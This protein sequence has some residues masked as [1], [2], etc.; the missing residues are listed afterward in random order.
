M[1]NLNKPPISLLTPEAASE[2]LGVDR[3][4]VYL[5]VADDKLPHIQLPDRGEI[6]LPMHAMLTSICAQGLE[7]GP[8]LGRLD[9]TA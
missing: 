1:S 3:E 4:K 2:L 6:R 7:I 5:L 8:D 9:D